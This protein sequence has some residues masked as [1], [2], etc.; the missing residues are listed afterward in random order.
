MKKLILACL[1]AASPFLGLFAQEKEKVTEDYDKNILK[2]NLTGLPFRNYGFQYERLLARKTSFNLGFRFMPNGAVPMLGTLEGVVDDPEFF[3]ELEKM[4]LGNIAVTPEFR[5]YLSK[6]P[7]ARGFYIAPFARYTRFDVTL[8]ELEFTVEDSN[9][10][11]LNVT[12]TADFKGNLTGMTGGL[13]LGAQWKLSKAIYLDWWIVGASFGS[14]KGD[15]RSGLVLN[16]DEQRA[17][18]QAVEDIE[19]PLLDYE[20]IFSNTGTQLKLDGPWAALRGG[21]SLGVKF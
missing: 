19:I 18:R 10:P 17:L 1:L 8:P 16:S 21:I 20:L 15:L 12:K 7:G 9:N 4:R 13:M 3:Q 14:G 2:L 6:K 5:F 11:A